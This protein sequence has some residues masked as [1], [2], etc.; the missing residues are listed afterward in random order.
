M[1]NWMLGENLIKTY[2]FNFEDFLDRK[3]CVD[4]IKHV[5]WNYTTKY[6]RIIW[7]TYEYDNKMK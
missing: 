4:R 5:D 6:I 3:V 1:F 2:Y 7:K